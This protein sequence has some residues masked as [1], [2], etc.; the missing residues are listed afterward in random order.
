M[1]HVHS[2]SFPALLLAE[3]ASSLDCVEDLQVCARAMQLGIRPAGIGG[4]TIRRIND[5]RKKN[6]KG[7]EA[8]IQL[9]AVRF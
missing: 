5:L 9:F 2:Q 4:G 7:A 8:S 1:P 3:S 6:K